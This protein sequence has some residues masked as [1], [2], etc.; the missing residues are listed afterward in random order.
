MKYQ[1]VYGFEKLF[2]CTGWVYC[3]SDNTTA[4]DNM[5]CAYEQVIVW[6]SFLLFLVYIYQLVVYIFYRDIPS[7]DWRI[8][9][10][11]LNAFFAFN[12]FAHFGFVSMV[13]ARKTHLILIVLS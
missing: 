1:D 10:F 9:I 12:V 13:F 3:Y 6:V 8:Y 4:P 11:Y 7:N 2:K 5:G